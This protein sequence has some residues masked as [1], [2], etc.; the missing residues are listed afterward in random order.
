[1][2]CCRCLH[3]R[4]EQTGSGLSCVYLGHKRLGPIIIVSVCVMSGV[5]VIAFVST[6]F[7]SESSHKIHVCTG[8]GTGASYRVALP[9]V[10][11]L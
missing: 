7:V 6:S 4:L 11:S 1:M 2:R 10:V 3:W 5:R 8:R 9:G